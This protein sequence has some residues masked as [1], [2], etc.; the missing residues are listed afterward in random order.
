LQKVP[1][2]CFRKYF[3]IPP[4]E[5]HMLRFILEAYEGIGLVTTL[6]AALGL[7]E[8]SI[9]PGCEEEVAQILNYEQDK[10]RLRSVWLGEEGLGSCRETSFVDGKESD[11]LRTR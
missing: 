3:I 7:I 11:I 2:A 8:M 10:L 5:I 9:A 1:K 4:S 6:D